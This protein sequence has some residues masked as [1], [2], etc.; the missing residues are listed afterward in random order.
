MPIGGKYTRAQTLLKTGRTKFTASGAHDVIEITS[1]RKN[2]L[3]TEKLRDRAKSLDE[4]SL[5]LRK[6]RFG[7]LFFR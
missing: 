6:A 7:C 3:C 2:D 5:L 4:V 1:P